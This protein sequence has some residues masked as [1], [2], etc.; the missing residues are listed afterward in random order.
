MRAAVERHVLDQVREPELIVFFEQRS[1]LDRE[2][3]RDALRRTRVRPDE[4]GETVGQLRRADGGVERDRVLQIE[5]LRDE[6]G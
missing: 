4:V 3:Q 5:C 6:N 1:G 2:A